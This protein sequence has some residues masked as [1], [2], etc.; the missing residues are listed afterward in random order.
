MKRKKCKKEDKSENKKRKFKRRL[1]K[2]LEQKIEVENCY[3]ETNWRKIK[4]NIKGLQR[5]YL[6]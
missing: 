5:K 1:N 4:K 6:E 3:I 2:M